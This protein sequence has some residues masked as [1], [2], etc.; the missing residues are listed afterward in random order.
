[1]QQEIWFQKYHIIRLLGSGGTARVYLA[2]HIKLNSYRAIKCISKSHPL[3]DLQRN[4]ALILKNLKHSCIPIIYDIEEDEEGSYI[5]EQYLEGETLKEYVSHGG[6][7]RDDIIIDYALQLCDLFHYMHSV[8]RPILYMDLKPEN[9]LVSCNRLKLIDFGSAIYQDE[10]TMFQKHAATR[11]YAAPELYRKGRLDDRCDVFGIGMLIYYMATGTEISSRTMQIAN[12]DQISICSKELKYIINH[13]L[14]FNPSQRYPTVARL[15]KHLSAINPERRGNPESSQG[16][17]IAV[18]GTQPRIGVTHLAF[19]LCHYMKSQGIDCLYREENRSQCI[20]RMRHNFEHRKDN[21]EFFVLKGIPMYTGNLN[22]EIVVPKASITL[23][24]YGTLS[25]ENLKDFLEADIRLLVIG[26]KEWELDYSEEVLEM[27]TEYKDII[28]L[29]NFLDGKQF[30]MVCKNMEQRCCYR[31]PYEP[32]PF[33]KL[34]IHNGLDL[35]RELVGYADNGLRTG[36]K[37][38]NKKG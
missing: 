11:G 10:N 29:F 31:I 17:T 5:V 18:A 14:R 33:Q 2:K 8:D 23:L 27:V 34:T 16:Q 24:D 37:L 1:M 25:K 12:I 30:Q 28:Y 35:F 20:H 9:L 6:P 4:E 3:Y 19:R 36:K 26:A 32:D 13:C 15:K 22:K 7:V 21:K 38:H